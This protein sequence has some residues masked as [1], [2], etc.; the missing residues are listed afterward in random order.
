MKLMSSASG[1]L[2]ATQDTAI[3]RVPLY[4]LRDSWG[5]AEDLG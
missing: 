1:V 4:T 3:K 2:E 5:Q